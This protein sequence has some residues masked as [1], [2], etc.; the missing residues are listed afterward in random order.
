M[1]RGTTQTG[2]TTHFAVKSYIQ[3]CLDTK[4][5]S[6]WMISVRRYIIQWVDF[7]NVHHMLTELSTVW[8]TSQRLCCLEMDRWRTNLQLKAL[9]HPVGTEQGTVQGGARSLCASLYFAWEELTFWAYCIYSIMLYWKII[10][11]CRYLVAF[12]EARVVSIWKGT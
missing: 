6:L 5:S 10:W 7:R 4:G 8:S 3:I 9:M 12:F 1:Q 2:G 11:H